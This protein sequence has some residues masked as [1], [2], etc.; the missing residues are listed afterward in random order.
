[1]VQETHE[2]L[3][4]FVQYYKA[5]F[6]REYMGSFS[7]DEG[8]WNPEEMVSGDDNLDL[9]KPFSLEEIKV[10]VFSCYPEGSL[11]PD[12]LPFL[13][14]QKFWDSVK[15]DLYSMFLEFHG[16]G[17]GGNVDSNT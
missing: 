8:F 13:F 11:G 2:I 15:D 17:G 12:G 10:D 6:R 7:L 16:G 1:M 3:E 5:L 4:V 9:E 14:F